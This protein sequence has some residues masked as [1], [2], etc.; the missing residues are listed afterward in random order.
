MGT[1]PEGS[2]IPACQLDCLRVYVQAEKLPVGLTG[3]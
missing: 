3:G 1:L 2:E